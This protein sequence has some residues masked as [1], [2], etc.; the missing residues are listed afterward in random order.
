MDTNQL[1][2]Y[3]TIFTEAWQ[4]FR[5]FSDPKEESWPQIVDE[6]KAFEGRYSNELAHDLMKVCLNELERVYK[7]K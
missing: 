7:A 2:E 5:K 1:K 4:F 3:W 6:A